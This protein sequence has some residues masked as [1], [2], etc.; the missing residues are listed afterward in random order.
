MS[1]LTVTKRPDRT[2]DI[3]AGSKLVGTSVER[4][5]LRKYL[6]RYCV[7]N[8]AVS[9]D[10]L[11]ELAERGKTRSTAVR[12]IRADIKVEP[13]LPTKRG[14]SKKS[15]APIFFFPVVPPSKRVR[16]RR[17]PS[18]RDDGPQASRTPDH[19]VAAFGWSR[20]ARILRRRIDPARGPRPCRQRPSATAELLDDAIM[21][22]G[23]PQH[24]AEVL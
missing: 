21:R 15:W 20:L 1:T 13:L 17:G 11:L 24:R 10:V 22:D 7:L 8:D 2:F 12:E 23:L 16:C 9:D 5:R 4:P 3:F 18:S 19:R 14:T 6:G